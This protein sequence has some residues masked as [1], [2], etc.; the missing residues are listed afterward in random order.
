MQSQAQELDPPADLI[1]LI[2]D[3]EASIESYRNFFGQIMSKDDIES[4]V[5]EI[6]AIRGSSMQLQQYWQSRLDTIPSSAD[7]D[8]VALQILTASTTGFWTSLTRTFTRKPRTIVGVEEIG[9]FQRV[10]STGHDIVG[11]LGP[12]LPY[13]SHFESE[14]QRVLN[15]TDR[16][17]LGLTAEAATA[18]RTLET[19]VD[20][21]ERDIQ[22]QRSQIQVISLYSQANA[23][24]EVRRLTRALTWLT[25]TVV[26][27]TLGVLIVSAI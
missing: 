6:S 25:V 19:I 3:L 18:R 9:I 4:S 12:A 22:A 8:S 20:E 7:V 2:S 27:L 24:E 17:S 14:C 5:G 1:L 23:A 16:E 21:I 15:S 26:A 10:S 13:V 11:A